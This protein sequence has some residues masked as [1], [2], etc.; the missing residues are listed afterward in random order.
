LSVL[1][2]TFVGIVAIAFG[3]SSYQAWFPGLAMHYGYITILGP[4]TAWILISTQLN[5]VARGMLALIIVT[6][7]VRAFEVNWEW[8]TLA[9][10]QWKEQNQAVRLDLSSRLDAQTVAAKDIALFY[11]VDSAPTRA[12]VA[13]GIVILREEGSMLSGPHQNR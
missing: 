7:F 12:V 1:L 11:F 6:L 3:R 8:R 2:A 4:V 10:S 13:R 5:R 9:A